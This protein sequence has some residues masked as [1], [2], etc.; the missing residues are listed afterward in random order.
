[1][2]INVK[3]KIPSSASAEL[4]KAPG[5]NTCTCYSHYYINPAPLLHTTEFLHSRGEKLMGIPMASMD[6]P[7][8]IY[9]TFIIREWEL[10]LRNGK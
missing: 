6:F 1:M 3:T 2:N 7:L 5:H 9:N 4:I 8:E 10:S